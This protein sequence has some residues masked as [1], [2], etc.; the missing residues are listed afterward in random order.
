MMH[1]LNYKPQI[2]PSHAEHNQAPVAIICFDNNPNINYQ[3]QRT[4]STT[5]QTDFFGNTITTIKD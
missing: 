2:N 5:G 1:P 3:L 4:T